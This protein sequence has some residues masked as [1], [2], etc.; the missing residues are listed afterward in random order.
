[1]D[2]ELYRLIAESSV[3]Y[4]IF[5]IGLDGIVKSWNP[6]AE[7]IFGFTPQEIV[8]RHGSILFVPEDV[9][10]GE[11][12]REMRFASETG[13]AQDSRWHLRKD[14]SR[15]WANGVMLGLRERTGTLRGLAKIVRDD[16]GLKQSQELLHYQLNLAD[17]IATRR[18]HCS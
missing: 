13:R 10:R 3:D 6:G 12:E 17:A 2:D 9:F 11:A 16:S 18:R 15:F 7:R 4:A 8:G 14:G 5:H 1:M